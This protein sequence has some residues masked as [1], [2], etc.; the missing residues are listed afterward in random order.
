MTVQMRIIR[1]WREQKIMLKNRFPFL[2][3]FD[4]DFEEG[5]RDTMLQKLEVRLN[6]SRSELE[7][8]FADLQ[9]Y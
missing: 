8:L 3:D 4:F 1:S 2:N 6:K 5:N 7:M 9:R